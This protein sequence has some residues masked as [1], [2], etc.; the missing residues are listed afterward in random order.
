MITGQLNSFFVKAV[1]T[2]GERKRFSGTLLRKSVTSTTH[3]KHP[4][5]I[6]DVA[7]HMDH[8]TKTAVK[9]YKVERKGEKAVETSEKLQLMLRGRLS[10]ATKVVEEVE[11]VEEEEEGGRGG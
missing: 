2:T 9:Y 1:G 8:D 3:Q 5:L 4:E 6:S 7:E 10:S 11:E